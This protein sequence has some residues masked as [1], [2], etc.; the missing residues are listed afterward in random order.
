MINGKRCAIV[1]GAARGIGK[2]ISLMLAKNGYAVCA[3]GTKP[4]NDERVSAYIEELTALSPESIYVQGDISVG[5]D[6][7]KIMDTAWNTFGTVEVLVNNAGVAPLVRNDLLEMTE[8]SYD[9]VVDINCR[10]VVFLTQLMARRMAQV[11]TDEPRSIV[12]ITSVSAEVSSISR[13]EYCVSKAGLSMA[14]KLYADRMARHGVNVYEV[15]PGII[16]TD[17]TAGVQ[18]KY[19]K[20]I[21]EGL[22]PIA[23]M[24]KPEDL[25]NTVLALANGAMRYSTGDVVNVDGGMMLRRL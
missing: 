19:Q 2:G 23:R 9:R 6:R 8:E 1:S 25:G 18:E 13:G 5:E 16:A 11:Q 21:D 20:M 22:M 10:S 14:V 3:V 12:F 24:G 7:E 15:R 17:M 4:A